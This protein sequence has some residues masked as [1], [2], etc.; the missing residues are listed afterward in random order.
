PQDTVFL[1][2]NIHT[3]RTNGLEV[4]ADYSRY[5]G[6]TRVQL[7]TSYTR[8]AADLGDVP[9]GTT[10]QYVLTNARH[11]LQAGVTLRWSA[12][13]AGLNGQWK[14]RLEGSSYGL[15]NLRLGYALHFGSRPLLL[16]AEVRNLF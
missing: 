9:E 8:L 5:I 10:Y 4:D 3:V 2:R 12:F 7:K 11:Q 13:T 6:D 14:D 15:M 16:T 1:A